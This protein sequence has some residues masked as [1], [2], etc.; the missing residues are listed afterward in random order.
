MKYLYKNALTLLICLITSTISAQN[1]ANI[2]GEQLNHLVETDDLLP[3]DLQFQINGESISRTSGI[4]HIYFSQV[5][6]DL[7]IFGTVSSIHLLPNGNV[8]SANNTFV[9]NT[10]DKLFG[11]ISPGLT[12]VQAVQAAALQLD[13][14]L[15]KPLSIKE[16]LQG[17]SMQG[18]LSDG[19][20]SLS[21]IPV[22]LMY[23][24]TDD[25]RL[26]LSWDISIE[27]KARQ[28]WW[29]IRVDAT[30]GKII[31]KTN[32]MLTC[33]L[34]H[35]HDHNVD[36]L[37]FNANLYD[38][39]N[40]NEIKNISKTCTVCYEVFALPL[41]NPYVGNRTIEVK[42]AHPTAS[43]YGWHDTNGI[44]GPEYT[45]TRGNNVNAY[46]SGDNYG[47]QPDGGT[48]LNFTGYPFS[49]IYSP[50]NQYEDASITNLFYLSNVFHDIAYQFGFDEVSGNFQENNYGKGGL[51]NDPVLAEGQNRMGSCNARISVPP[52]G[53]SPQMAIYTCDDKDGDFDTVVVLHEYGHG[54]SMRLTG[55]PRNVDCLMNN[56]QMGEGW[57][58]YF[59]VLLTIQPG[60]DGTEPR[61][62]GSYLLGRS[63]RDYPYSTDMAVNPQTY[64]YIK[65]ASIPHGVGS[66]WAEMLWEMTWALINKHGYDPNPYNFSGDINIDKGNTIAMAIVMEAM[67]LQ[68]CNPGF[69]DARDAIFAA[70]LAIYGGTN[71]CEI[72]EAFAKRG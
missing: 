7:E 37:D 25:E 56:E 35:D 29:S 14:K 46:E 41:A 48:H 20:I 13:Y 3:Q 57:S 55:G 15:V 54:I 31:N 65:S 32:W 67:K 24:L 19:G 63:I 70:D 34:P 2:I 68:P 66:V 6:N 60:D 11:A 12:A 69:V 58:D 28:N 17:S 49:P 72:W 4:H 53:H 16:N 8:L 62:I 64:D 43:P 9:N 59:G 39:P 45:V 33:D 50:L 51:G 23:T 61:E 38:I 18:L 27:E 44:S 10:A 26:V 52:E 47:Y 42:P 1:I 71:E 21:P 22:K 30:T 5:F 36:V 40:N